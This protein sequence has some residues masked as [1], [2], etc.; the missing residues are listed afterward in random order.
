MNSI[1]NLIEYWPFEEC[2]CR[3][4]IHGQAWADGRSTPTEGG[5][6]DGNDYFDLLMRAG[7]GHMAGKPGRFRRL[8]RHPSPEEVT[9]MPI[10]LTLYAVILTLAVWQ[11]AQGTHVES[12]DRSS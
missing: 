9:T 11:D 4:Y 6:P 2:Q 7:R 5:N 12:R 1:H 8:S 3:L 10:I